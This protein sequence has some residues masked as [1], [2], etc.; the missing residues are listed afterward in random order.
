MK[1][2]QNRKEDVFM[3][4]AVIMAGGKGTRFWPL[5][6][7]EKPKQ[8]LNLLG[9]ETMIRMTV[10]RLLPIIP[11]ERIFVVTGKQ[12][13]DL[14]KTELPELDEENIIVEPM[15]RNTAPCIALSAF[16]IKK[17]YK[18]STMVVV[19]SDHLIKE[20]KKF[21]KILKSAEEFVKNKEEALVT[22]GITPTRPETGYG[23]INSS[24]EGEQCGENQ[25]RPVIKFV[26]KPSIGKALEYLRDGNYLWNS[27]MIVSKCDN[28]LRLI[29]KH[30][31]NTYEILKEVAVAD[32]KVYEEILE[33]KYKRVDNIS[34]DFG[35]MEKAENIY[36]IPGDFGWDDVGS[37]KALERYRE[38][39]E[40][41]NITVGDIKVINGKNNIIIG[42]EKPIIVSGLEDI[43]LVESDDVIILGKKKQ[44]DTINEIRKLNI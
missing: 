41:N 33:K 37:W 32:D 44:I 25:I 7:E 10:E 34:I 17:R 23:Y 20:E 43:F 4:C 28:I 39:D 42:G 27:G 14:V 5:S 38:K 30:L 1:E 3:L 16:Y 35:V 8:F 24:S 40:N 36:V 12:Y 2:V 6:T 21:L 31:E 26:E 9:E 29:A 13:V 18:D 11:I 19:P 22:I 15:G